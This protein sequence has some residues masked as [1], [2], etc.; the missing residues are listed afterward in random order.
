MY[1]TILDGYGSAKHVSE[2]IIEEA[3]QQSGL[4]ATI[5]RVGNIAGPVMRGPDKGMW[6]KHDWFPTVLYT[7]KHLRTIP[8]TLGSLDR[9]DWIPVDLVSNIL[10]ELAGI[11]PKYASDTANGHTVPPAMPVYHAVNPTPQDWKS[12]LPGAINLLGGPQKI[13]V[14]PYTEWLEILRNASPEEMGTI[15]LQESTALKLLD[16]FHELDQGEGNR[17]PA[18]ETK[19]SREH[20]KGMATL[21]PVSDEWIELWFKQWK[22]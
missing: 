11:S 7:S 1:K 2:L 9:V 6:A 5:C 10:V 12:L 22:F 15:N 3:V 17:W 14:V 16:F 18:L 19:K 8:A 4:R 21:P 20:S 13:K